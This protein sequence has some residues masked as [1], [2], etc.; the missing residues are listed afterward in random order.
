MLS[1]SSW[2][3]L[4]GLFLPADVILKA[5]EARTCYPSSQLALDYEVEKKYNSF[6]HFLLLQQRLLAGNWTGS[7]LYA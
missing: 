6:Q 5:P 1:V 4:R 2:S 7:N 3:R